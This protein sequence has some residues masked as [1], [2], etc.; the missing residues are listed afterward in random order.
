MFETSTRR[1]SPS[2][3]PSGTDDSQTPG[4]TGETPVLH[5]RIDSSEG[6]VSIP[7]TILNPDWRAEEPE[8]AANLIFQKALVGKMQPYLA[9]VK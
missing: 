3:N 2:A 1:G 4:W 7:G 9:I 5:S 6:G 8:C